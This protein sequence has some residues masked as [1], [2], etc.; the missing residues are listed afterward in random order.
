MMKKIHTSDLPKE[1]KIKIVFYDFPREV[2]NYKYKNC[3]YITFFCRIKQDLKLENDFIMWNEYL[4]ISF[5]LITFQKAWQVCVKRPKLNK[6]TIKMSLI[7]TKLK[8]NIYL[9]DDIIELY[10]YGVD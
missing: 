2:E 9:F 3:K 5:P 6:K 4:Y 7:F 1:Q 8:D 10:K